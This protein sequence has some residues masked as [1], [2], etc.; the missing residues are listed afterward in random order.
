MLTS[1]YQIIIVVLMVIF[2]VS[3]TTSLSDT[4]SVTG[5]STLSSS[6]QVA[7][8][9]TISGDTHITSTTTSTNTTTG[10]L[11]VNGGV[12][13]SGKVNIG[14]DLDVDGTTTLT[15]SDPNGPSGSGE[16]LRV[17]HFNHSLFGDIFTVSNQGHTVVSNTFTELR[18][19]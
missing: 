15:G 19:Q 6:L 16:A 4:L 8:T 14:S 11:K 5:A 7:G 13:I 9:T 17:R 12:G 3:G 18:D 10:A 1:P 2:L